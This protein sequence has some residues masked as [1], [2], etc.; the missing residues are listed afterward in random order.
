MFRN[1][2][3]GF[4]CLAVFVLVAG[5]VCFGGYKAVRIT[6]TISGSTGIAGVVMKGLPGDPVCDADGSYSVTVDYGWK[7]SVV[8]IKEGFVFEPGEL[9]YAKVVANQVDQ[10][11][12]GSLIRL[13][14]SGSAGVI[15][16][17]MKGLG[18]EVVSDE[19]GKYSAVVDYGWQGAITPVKEGYDFVPQ[20]N[21][22]ERITSNQT[23]QDF[24]ANLK[25]FTISGSTGLEGVVLKGFGEDIVSNSKGRYSVRVDY[26]WNGTVTAVLEGYTF[27]PA[28][29][30]YSKVVGG[31]VHQ[32]YAADR[33]TLT[34]SGNTGQGG[35]LLKG[36]GGNTVSDERGDYSAKVD[37][38]FS[39]I[40]TPA[41]EGY[42]FKPANIEY[43]NLKRD[44]VNERYSAKLKTF[45]VSGSA[46]IGG[47]VMKGLPGDP[48]TNEDGTYAALVNYG[49]DGVVVPVKEGHSFEPSERIYKSVSVNHADQSYAGQLLSFIVSGVVARDASPVSKVSIEG[50][51]GDPITNEDG[52]YSVIVDYGWEGTVTAKK[53][54]YTFEPE[55]VTYDKVTKDISRDYEATLLTFA[56]SGVITFDGQPLSDVV[57]NAGEGGPSG[58]TDE[59]GKYEIFVDYGFR[60]SVRPEKEGYTFEP[61]SRFTK[62]TEMASE[63]KYRRVV[64]NQVNQD[65]AATILT[66]TICGTVDIGDEPVEGVLMSASNGGGTCM[67]DAAG[68]Y[69]LT[70]DYGW[71]GA[72]TP[73]KEGYMFDPPSIEYNNVTCDIDEDLKEA[74]RAAAIAEIDELA[75]LVDP[76]RADELEVALDIRIVVMGR[77]DLLDLGFEWGDPKIK[78]GTVSDSQEEA[79]KLP[80]GIKIGRLPDGDLAAQLSTVLGDLEKSGKASIV[81]NPELLTCEGEGTEIKVTT[82]EY[83]SLGDGSAEVDGSGM[84]KIEYQTVL[85]IIPHVLS[86]GILLTLDIE[87][88]EVAIWGENSQVLA[89]RVVSDT[90]L[91][92]EGGT[93][94]VAGLSNDEV[95]VD[96]SEDDGEEAV[97]FVSAHLAGV[98]T[99]P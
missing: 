11:Y 39:G 72:V 79:G 77:D 90:V 44:K 13:T 1:I 42:V 76:G 30:T 36:L 71:S 25:T 8:P 43:S 18:G 85:N 55:I 34:V 7:G 16:A 51:P 66:F 29:R 88:S 46:G 65:Y 23:D 14:I 69:L 20:F 87:V 22:Y 64:E 33:I 32:D 31:H 40:V 89:Q 10:D 82:E 21:Q 2:S 60:G 59:S 49:W 98:Y 84:E 97:I 63:R 4:I 45:T 81:S 50:L 73:S 92:K 28:G 9:S 57:V 94:S 93:V 80:L 15:G 70:V 83:Y 53:K 35:V 62:V 24:T 12:E 74:A 38:D 86:K 54:G 91:I 17:A 61:S 5:A 96:G 26:G 99:E 58:K 6:Y 52:Y 67:T 56:V 37:Y 47:V 68:K 95:G 27:D 19:N 75:K 78:D 3:R 48:V 41:K